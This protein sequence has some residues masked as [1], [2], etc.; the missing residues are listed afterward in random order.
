MK[1]Q[2]CEGKD[3]I[4]FDFNEALRKI[5]ESIDVVI[6]KGIDIEIKIP[7]ELVNSLARCHSDIVQYFRKGFDNILPIKSCYNCF[8]QIK[9]P[10]LLKCNSSKGCNNYDKWKLKQ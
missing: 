5:K 6:E 8:Y 3:E 2:K 7:V 10:I 4:K 9:N 1:C